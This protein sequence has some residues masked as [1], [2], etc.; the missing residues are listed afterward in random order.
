[1]PLAARREAHS[2][3]AGLG[4]EV[5]AGSEAEVTLE[6]EVGS[7]EGLAWECLYRKE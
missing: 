5:E 1:M 7:E 6:Q 2:G 3:M 4:T